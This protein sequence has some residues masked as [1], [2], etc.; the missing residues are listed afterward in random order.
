MPEVT[1]HVAPF[2]SERIIGALA[3]HRVDYVLIGAL[4]A[5]LYGFPRVT[6]DIDITPS[7]EGDNL[8]RLAAA[9]RELKARVFT[10]SVPEGLAFDCSRKTLA[11]AAMWNLVTSAG[12]LDVAFVPAGTK[13]YADLAGSAERFEVFDATILVA[14]LN[15]IIRSKTAAD[16]PQDRQDVPVLKA[17]L[18]RQKR[19]GEAR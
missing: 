19:E 14:S 10:E 16:R 6:A 18:A 8:E 7:R 3:R 17:I 2:D 5:R 15:D 1:P 11:G 9:L 13:G 12:R 4:A